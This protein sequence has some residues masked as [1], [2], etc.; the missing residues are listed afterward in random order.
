M[1]TWNEVVGK[2]GVNEVGSCILEYVKRNYLILEEGRERCLVVWSDRCKGQINNWQIPCLL[3]YLMNQNYFTSVKQRFLTSGHTFLPCDRLFAL[4]EKH[5]MKASV[6]VPEDWNTVIRSTRPH[7]PFEMIYMTQEL[8]Y[9]IKSLERV[10]Q[11]PD[12]LLVSQVACIEIMKND[13]ASIRT[14]ASHNQVDWIIHR[15]VAPFQL[16]RI[17]NRLHW[18]PDVLNGFQLR[19]TY[20]A[21][22]PLSRDKWDDLISFLPFILPEFRA[23]YEQ[24]PHA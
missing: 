10:M 1:C 8:F 5:R 21:L 11:H 13:P 4:I 12:T 2:R 17:V 20:N 6:I 7:E 15:M 3:Q 9:D 18:R 19:Q 22:L 24:L 16:G 14:K 23:F